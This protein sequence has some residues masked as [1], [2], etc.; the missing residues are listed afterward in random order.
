M[1]DD[2]Q[3]AAQDRQGDRQEHAEDYW[4]EGY[5]YY[6]P[7]YWHGGIWVGDW[8]EAHVYHVDDDEGV[9][10]AGVVAGFARGT[11]I[12]AAVCGSAPSGAGGAVTAGGV[13]GQTY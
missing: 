8:D 3:Q 10:W 6:G 4:E 2:R 13:D 1:Q 9:E 5:G 12:G 11:V 7:A